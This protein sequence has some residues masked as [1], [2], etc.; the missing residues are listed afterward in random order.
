[1]A[2]VLLAVNFC[3][4]GYVLSSMMKMQEESSVTTSTLP[5][6][7]PETPSKWVKEYTLTLEQIE[8]PAILEQLSNIRGL[9]S[10]YVEKQ[11]ELLR[12]K[13]GPD[14]LEK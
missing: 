5:L 7:V 1:V 2:I 12:K 3:L 10:E 13:Q 8:D 11:N 4:T 9:M 14:K 6:S